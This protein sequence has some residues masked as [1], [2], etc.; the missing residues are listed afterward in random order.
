MSNSARGFWIEGIIIR[1]DCKHVQLIIVR[2]LLYSLND[3]KYYN[4]EGNADL[5]IMIEVVS[6]RLNVVLGSGGL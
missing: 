4:V 3:W 5:A 2:A 1:V 6:R